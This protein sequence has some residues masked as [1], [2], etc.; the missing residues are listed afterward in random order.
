MINQQNLTKA[1]WA[2]VWAALGL[3]GLLGMLWPWP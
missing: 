1:Q 2:L 3:A